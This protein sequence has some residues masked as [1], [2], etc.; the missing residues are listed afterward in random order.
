MRLWFAESDV[1]DSRLVLARSATRAADIFSSVEGIAPSRVKEV[2][3][4]RIPPHWT[5]E[6]F[7]PTDD[8]L[9]A[10]GARI[11]RSRNVECGYL[12]DVVVAHFEGPDGKLDVVHLRSHAVLPPRWA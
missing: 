1:E 4:A 5:D 6:D 2:R 8:R 9:L 3:F 7:A 12:C 11:V 10:M